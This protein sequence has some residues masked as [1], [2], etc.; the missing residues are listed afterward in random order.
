M[1]EWKVKMKIYKKIF[2]H[3]GSSLISKFLIEKF[4]NDFDELYIFCRNINKT[5]SILEV[6]KYS[7]KKIIFFENDLENIKKTTE[8]LNKLPDDLNGIFWVTGVTGNPDEEY[9]NPVNIEKNLN[10]NFLH[11]VLCISLLSTKIVKNNK[12]FICAF[13]SVAGLRGRKK[14]LYYSSAKSGLITYL[15]GLRQ[16]FNGKIKIFTVIPGYV[17]TNTFSENASKILISSP[18]QCAEIVHKNIKQNKE[19]IYVNYIWKI[20]MT[21]I[22]FIPEKIFKKLQ[23]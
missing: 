17:S 1:K 3:G 2:I 20:I 6:E 11:P 16:K 7:D 12:S 23:F 22:S 5:K 13:T 4:K 21:I 15:S 10:I 8:D 18:K 14:R 9:N 19:I